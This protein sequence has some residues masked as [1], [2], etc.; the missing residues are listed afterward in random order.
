MQC[1][2]S[3]A[4]NHEEEPISED[5][6]ARGNNKCKGLKTDLIYLRTQKKKKIMFF[7]EEGVIENGVK[8]KSMNLVIMIGSHW[9]L[10]TWSDLCFKWRM[11]WGVVSSG[12]KHGS[13]RHVLS[14]SRQE[15]C[16]RKYSLLRKFFVIIYHF[17]LTI[18]GEFFRISL[19]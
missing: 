12:S 15:Q 19:C 4:L 2:L 18:L 11:D 7:I 3:W 16:S 8:K 17:T 14:L 6:R 13:R 1:C 9:K 5:L 10:I